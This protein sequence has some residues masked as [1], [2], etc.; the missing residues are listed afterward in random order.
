MT[1]NE[2]MVNFLLVRA[3]RAAKR[4]KKHVKFTL[5]EL[6]EQKEWDW[7]SSGIK[8]LL[9]KAFKKAI[10]ESLFKITDEVNHHKQQLYYR[11]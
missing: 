3:L 8:W 1:D 7:I 9:G 5:N 11:R 10:D 6:F 4:K 2:A